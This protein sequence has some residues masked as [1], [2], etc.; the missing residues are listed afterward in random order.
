MNDLKGVWQLGLAKGGH[1]KKSAAL[2]KEPL[3]LLGKLLG[4]LHMVIKN[5]E[6]IGLPNFFD[7]GP[8]QTIPLTCTSSNDEIKQ[9]YLFFLNYT[10][11]H[12][13][14]TDCKNLETRFQFSPHR[15]KRSFWAFK[16]NV[17]V[18]KS[19][20]W[21]RILGRPLWYPAHAAAQGQTN[22]WRP[23]KNVGLFALV[24]G[25][26][27]SAKSYGAICLFGPWVTSPGFEPKPKT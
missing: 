25:S 9:L 10:S 22:K 4:C 5:N 15:S 26:T 8:V 2:S 19:W 17:I 20:A 13:C 16:L 23:N 24:S 7:D 1:A 27:D 21:V 3:C 18:H 6:I 14:F 11:W 12:P